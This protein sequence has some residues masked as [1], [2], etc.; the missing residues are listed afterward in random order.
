MLMSYRLASSDNRRHSTVCTIYYRHA[1]C[2]T[3][4]SGADYRFVGN[5]VLEGE[6]AYADQSAGLE[7]QVH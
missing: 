6:H 5:K 1:V 7:V 2:Y 3:G 4:N